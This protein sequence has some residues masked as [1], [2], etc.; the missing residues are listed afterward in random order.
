MS[1][2]I[3]GLKQANM[4]SGAT[5]LSQ[6]FIYDFSFDQ[7]KGAIGSINTGIQ[8]PNQA[9]VWCFVTYVDTSLVAAGTIL[10]LG[11]SATNVLFGTSATGSV[12]AGGYPFFFANVTNPAVMDDTLNV[13][14]QIQNEPITAGRFTCMFQYF[15]F[16]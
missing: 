10:N 13:I 9:C 14:L 3:T 7:T 4:K 11:T 15:L 5:F 12:A 6:A 16:Q 1:I 2:T 8:F